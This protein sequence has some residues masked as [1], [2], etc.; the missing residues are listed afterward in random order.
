MGARG[1]RSPS[2]IATLAGLLALVALM[3]EAP[4][5]QGWPTV[6]LQAARGHRSREHQAER[7]QYLR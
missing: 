2:R 5:S 4:D 6:P 1:Q 7:A 3:I